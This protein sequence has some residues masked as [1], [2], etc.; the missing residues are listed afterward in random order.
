MRQSDYWEI[1]DINKAVEKYTE[2]IKSYINTGWIN[3]TPTLK[4]YK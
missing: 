1:K 3:S 2:I 4:S